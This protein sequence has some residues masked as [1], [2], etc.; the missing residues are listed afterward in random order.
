MAQETLKYWDVDSTV[1]SNHRFFRWTKR[2][3]LFV[4]K[5]DRSLKPKFR[6]L[7]WLK[8]NLFCIKVPLKENWFQNYFQSIITSH[9]KI[10]NFKKFK[11][12]YEIDKQLSILISSRSW[13][14]RH[15]WINVLLSITPSTY[16]QSLHFLF[17]N[18]HAQDCGILQCTSLNSKTEMNA[19]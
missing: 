1:Y 7:F 19:S 15:L 13:K 5:Q 9:L 18:C 10:N 17:T 4:S 2:R 14:N 8:G 16:V 6:C 3:W 12:A 11:W